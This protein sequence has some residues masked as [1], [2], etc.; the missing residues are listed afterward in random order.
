M[1]RNLILNLNEKQ[2]KLDNHIRYFKDTENY[3][4]V[5]GQL[6]ISIQNLKQKIT[7]QKTSS[8]KEA[9]NGE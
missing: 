6:V 5:Y 2:E 1:Q 7:S 3:E 8:T 9:K 4:K